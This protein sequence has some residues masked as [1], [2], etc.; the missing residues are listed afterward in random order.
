M[1]EGHHGGQ[2]GAGDPARKDFV[3]GAGSHPG[4][5]CPLIYMD[6]GSIRLSSDF[7][8]QRRER[9]SAGAPAGVSSCGHF[10]LTEKKL[11]SPPHAPSMGGRQS[12]YT[13][14]GSNRKPSVS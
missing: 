14:P 7:D 8:S 6:A 11:A 1:G 10:F 3:E 12:R 9:E 13:P 5:L 2:P 4:T